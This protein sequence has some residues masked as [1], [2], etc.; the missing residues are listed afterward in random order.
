[1][2]FPVWR[3]FV[4]RGYRVYYEKDGQLHLRT[5]YSG[6]PHEFAEEV[7]EASPEELFSLLGLEDVASSVQRRVPSW[8]YRSATLAQEI[9]AK[10]LV[11]P[12]YAITCKISSGNRPGLEKFLWSRNGPE[13]SSGLL[14][15]PSP[16]T[17]SPR[18]PWQRGWPLKAP[19]FISL[20]AFEYPN[21][22]K[23]KAI[24]MLAEAAD[25]PAAPLL[26]SAGYGKDRR[27]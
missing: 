3:F 15:T 21:V 19:Q 13:S 14:I 18:G 17:P 9:M 16:P 26:R 11:R 20:L 1:L 6:F 4:D 22:T 25:A 12:S 24:R 5:N 10:G 8:M 23:A 7:P 27:S 2:R